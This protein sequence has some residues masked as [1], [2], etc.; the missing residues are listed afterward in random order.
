MY[1][2]KLRFISL[3]STVVL[4]SLLIIANS[5]SLFVYCLF[6]RVVGFFVSMLYIMTVSTANLCFILALNCRSREEHCPNKCPF[7]LHLI[8]INLCSQGSIWE[9]I[10]FFIFCIAV[11]Y[12]LYLCIPFL[13]YTVPALLARIKYPV[14]K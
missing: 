7:D 11:A 13:G 4:F 8:Y 14:V 12:C 5:K 2:G 1:T 9:I 3:W 6:V 10:E